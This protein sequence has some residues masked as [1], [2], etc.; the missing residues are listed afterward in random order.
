MSISWQLVVFPT[1]KLHTKSDVI[2]FLL[3]CSS[4][5]SA[6]LEKIPTFYAGNSDHLRLIV[7]DMHTHMCPPEAR[8]AL[9]TL[10]RRPWPKASQRSPYEQ[11]AAQ[12]PLPFAQIRLWLSLFQANFSSPCTS[13]P[14]SA[15]DLA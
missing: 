2:L 6:A 15:R 11:V 10:Y 8:E 7:C 12:D 14:C 9:P 1:L 5:L 3:R 4:W 13:R